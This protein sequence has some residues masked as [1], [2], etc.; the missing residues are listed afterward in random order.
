[1]LICGAHC[2]VGLPSQSDRIDIMGQMTYFLLHLLAL[3]ASSPFWQ[4]RD[5]GRAS[6][7]LTVFDNLPRTGLPSESASFGEFQRSVD[8]LVDLGMIEDSS[9]IWWD[10]RPSAAFPTLETRRFWDV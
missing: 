2:H 1:M 5:T 3:S 6:Y 8:L 7:R 10:L 4:G 9:K